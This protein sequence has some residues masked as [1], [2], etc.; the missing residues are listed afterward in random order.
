[1]IRARREQVDQLQ[2]RRDALSAERTEVVRKIDL[3]RNEITDLQSFMD[4]AETHQ[5]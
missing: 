3:T 2:L 5:P 4:W 1:M